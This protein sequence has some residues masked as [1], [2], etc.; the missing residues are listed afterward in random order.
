MDPT[1]ATRRVRIALIQMAVAPDPDQN[2]DRALKQ[3]TAA[4][5]FGA[6]I[7]C[8]P[9][10]FCS[11]YFPQYPDRDAG[12]YAETV[13]GRSTRAL[14]DLARRAGVTIIAPVYEKDR[15]GLCYNT[16]C[17]LNPAGTL[18][19]PYRK[20]HIPHDPLFYEKTY[21]HPGNAYRVYDTPQARFAVLI[22]YDQWFPEAARIVTLMGAEIIFYPTAIGHIID[23]PP[24]EGEDTDWPGAWET[25]QRGHAIANGVYVAAVNRTGREDR[26]AFFGGSFVCDAFGQPMA[27]AGE[28]AEEILVADLD[29]ALSRRIRSGWG[30]LAHRRPDTYG[31]LLQPPSEGLS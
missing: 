28:D 27:K 9:E 13:P 17:V 30:F 4:A 25:I 11:P 10:L 20:V 24:A 23:A 3:A 14:G 7:I 5:E 8:L 19:P 22:C 15:D 16:A 26:L 31:P 29:L 6:R 2:L 18:L 1:Q 12:H 21:F